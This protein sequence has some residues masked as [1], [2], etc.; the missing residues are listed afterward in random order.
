MTTDNQTN[1]IERWTLTPEAKAKIPE[2]NERWI[3]LALSCDP[4][5][6]PKASEAVKG[7]Y[8]ASKCNAPKAIVRC[9]SPM[10]GAVVWC[11]AA[12]WW[13]TVAK[14]MDNASGIVSEPSGFHGD[15]KQVQL[16]THRAVMEATARH[17][18]FSPD[19]RVC[20]NV[21]NGV[22]AKAMW[23][24]AKKASTDGLPDTTAAAV[25]E[26]AEKNITHWWASHNAGSEWCAACSFI[27]FVRDIVG[28]RHPSHKEYE[29]YENATIHGGHRF[30]ASDF[31]LICDRPVARRT[32][33]R[34]DVYILHNPQGPSIT[35]KCG[36]VS[37]HIDGLAVD[38]QIVLRPETQ[39]VSQIDGET[40][41]DIRAIRLQRFGTVRYLKESNAIC[42]DHRRNDI[43]GTLET[44]CKVEK[45]GHKFLLAT[46]PSG[47]NCPPLPVPD[48]IQDC[49]QAATWL[50]GDNPSQSRRKNI[51]AR[52]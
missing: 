41:N 25:T 28:F 40:N 20:P 39:T 32:E 6:F 50:A 46:C 26:L 18:P 23:A 51:V 36:T 16:D 15:V 3:K 7:M 43:E 29:F 42:I 33:F 4:I 13:D 52:T 47:R 12:A 45:T 34:N 49:A 10:Q 27:S 21:D 30:V 38:E 2:W 48:T 8:L 9:M 5:D 11:W 35:W 37:W 44:L 24:A 14:T 1:Q 17:S 22:I 31:C 19:L